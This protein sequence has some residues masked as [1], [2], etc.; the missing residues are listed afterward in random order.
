MSAFVFN[1]DM[2]EQLQKMQTKWLAKN[3][4]IPIPKPGDKASFPVAC[5]TGVCFKVTPTSM[6][7]RWNAEHNRLDKLDKWNPDEGK[8]ERT[9]RWWPHKV[10]IPLALFCGTVTV[11]EEPKV[12]EPVW[13]DCNFIEAVEWMKKEPNKNIAQWNGCE[14]WMSHNHI[15]S[16]QF[17]ALLD[18]N[19]LEPIL[20]KWQIKVE[21]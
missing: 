21:G 19:S 12:P 16:K 15:W 9:F 17:G 20:G 5:V 6:I 2:R 11:V 7:F 8:Q 3:K 18:C 4:I 1:E 13:K 10:D 14:Y